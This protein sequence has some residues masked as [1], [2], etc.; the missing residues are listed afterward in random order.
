MKNKKVLAM[1]LSMSIVGALAI[2]GTLA[3]LTSSPEEVVN[4]FNIS[5]VGGEIDETDED[6]KHVKEKD[7]DMMP[8]KSDSKDPTVHMDMK[9][10][11][12]PSYVVIEVEEII[13]PGLKFSFSD[14]IEYNVRSEHWK[15]LNEDDF[16]EKK[17][18]EGKAGIYY[19]EYDPNNLDDL[20]GE[21]E[22]KTDLKILTDVDLN[23]DGKVDEEPYNEKY[24]GQGVTYPDTLSNEMMQALIDDYD[25]NGNAI[26]NKLPQLKFRV[27]VIQKE[28]FATVK[29][30]LDE[31]KV[32]KQE[33]TDDSVAAKQ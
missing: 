33:V 23:G 5:T 1:V 2:G 29:E 4:T 12:V 22:G 6:G 31:T 32:I 11:T 9:E 28:G 13:K 30:A 3:W 18:F 7:Y 19:C 21:V 15:Q 24:D 26:A 10:T 16:T 17:L 14:Y 27:H 25:D 8:G 20:G